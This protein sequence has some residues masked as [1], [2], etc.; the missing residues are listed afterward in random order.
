MTLQHGELSKNLFGSTHMLAVMA[1]V[2][3]S[4]DGQFSAPQ[5]SASTGLPA[6]TVHSL[7]MRLRRAELIR[8]TGE[9]TAERIAI[10]ERRPSPVWGAASA[11][12]TEADAVQAGTVKDLW[13]Q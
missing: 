1:E 9:V 3:R 13:N 7:F 8:R 2:D 5:V 11:I 10:Y 4:V 12:A 6:S